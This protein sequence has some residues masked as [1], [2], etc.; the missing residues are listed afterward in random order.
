MLR[1][2]FFTQKIHFSPFFISN[3]QFV[4]MAKMQISRCE[5]KEKKTGVELMDL[6]LQIP[7]FHEI[8]ILQ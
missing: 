1:F 5:L 6:S 7:R 2:I 4:T 3:L 8:R